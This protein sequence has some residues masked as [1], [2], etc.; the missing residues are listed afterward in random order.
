[1]KIKTLIF[2]L[3]FSLF[4]NLFSQTMDV[5]TDSGYIQVDS[6]KLFYE[7]A[8][9]GENIVLIHDGVVHREVW[10]AQFP[11]FAKNYRVIRYDR[12]GFGKSPNP[13]APFSNIDDLNQ[14]FIQ[15]K[16]EKAVIFGMSSGG[17]L[18]IDF[19]LKYPDKV[20]ALVLVGA[21]VGGYGYTSHMFT[22]G[23]HAKNLAEILAD[24]QKTIEYFARE[25]PYEIYKENVKAK[26]KFLKLLEANPI[27][28]SNEK[29]T[30]LKRPDVIAV[31]HLGE[32]KVP[33]LILTGEFDIPDVHAHAGVIEFGIP[34]ARREIIYNSGHLIP[35]EQPDAFN[36][37]SLKFLGNVEFFN[38]LNTLGVDA[39][40]KYY[41]DKR[42]SEPGIILFDENEMNSL[43]YRFLQNGKTIDAI[44]VFKLNVIAYPESW[45]VYDSLGEA[46]LKDDQ[47]D[48][49]IKN[50]EK[51]LEL[52]PDN[53]NAQKVL[54]NLKNPK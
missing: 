7:A 8:G 15:L 23:G 54:Q 6:G 19:A 27:N 2:C 44:E 9:K 26:E 25:D 37:A 10:D 32:I 21:V 20:K 41:N 3:F 34:N 33:A 12:R 14:L 22:R 45:N 35:L 17:G 28:L 4:S 47:K 39:A 50:Y 16:L 52:N 29:S 1:M 38:I 24:P 48:L 53:S 49:A 11:V 46:Y 43:G 40:A 31:K 5:K 13:S 30:Y 51:S 18:A 36:E 42:R